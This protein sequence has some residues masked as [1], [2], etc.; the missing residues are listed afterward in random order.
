MIEQNFKSLGVPDYLLKAIEENG[1]TNPTDIQ[2]EVIP[3]LLEFNSDVVGQAQTGTG[4]TAAFAIPIISR[5]EANNEMIQ[6]LILAPTRELC[7]QIQKEIFKLTK[8]TTGVYSTAVFGGEKIEIQ[9]S[10]LSKP[11]QILVATPGR[12]LDLLEKDI[13]NLQ[14]VHTVVLDEADEM[15]KLGFQKD[16]EKILKMTHL[17][18]FT[19]LFSA[20]IPDSL[21]LIISN[22]LSKD[23][24]RFQVSKKNSVN[25]DIEHQYFITQPKLKIEYLQMFLKTQPKKNGIFFTRTKASA[26]FVFDKLSKTKLNVGVLHGDLMQSDREKMIRM[27]KKGSLQY[28][29]ATDIAARGIDVKG[30]SFVLHYELPDDIENYTHRS[31]RTGRAGNKGISIAFIEKNELKRIFKIESL[32]NIKFKQIK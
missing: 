13:I 3:Y 5:A 11:T 27:F 14:S 1:Y 15:L 31:G 20:T 30:L 8:F 7:Q 19:W 4:K 6:S 25:Q 9:I 12:L 28:L 24:K 22:Y 32:L 26:Q 17:N 10:K 21:Q 18:S 16:V 2:K 29:V 23:A